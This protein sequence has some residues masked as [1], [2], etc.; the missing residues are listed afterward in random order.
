MKI[1]ISKGGLLGVQTDDAETAEKAL[2]TI[3]AVSLICGLPTSLVHKS[4]VA[5]IRFEDGFEMRAS[6]WMMSSLRMQ[7][8]DSLALSFTSSRERRIQIS[9][10]DLEL[11]VG[12]CKRVWS[13][14]KNH[15][16]LELLLSAHTFLSS[17]IYWQDNNRAAHA[18]LMEE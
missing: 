7:A 8:F 11:I 16:L 15:R 9:L 13:A 6:E 1:A 14:P 5:R 18:R 2:N 12:H 3:M 17:D 4:E 10:E